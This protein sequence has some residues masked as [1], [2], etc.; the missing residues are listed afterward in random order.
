MLE[1]NL[2][3]WAPFARLSVMRKV[4]RQHD[5]TTEKTERPLSKSIQTRK[6]RAMFVK[7]TLCQVWRVRCWSLYEHDCQRALETQYETDDVMWWF[8]SQRIWETNRS[9][10][11]HPHPPPPQIRTETAFTMTKTEKERESLVANEKRNR[12]RQWN[13]TLEIRKNAKF[14]ILKATQKYRVNQRK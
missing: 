6:S 7:G 2:W 11:T 13:M 14:A 9:W 12:D 5:I 1:R 4:K 8:H 10:K 3:K